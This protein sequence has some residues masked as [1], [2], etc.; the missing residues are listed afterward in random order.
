MN[1]DVKYTYHDLLSI[2]SDRHRYE[3]FQGDL[4]MT[5]APGRI[6]QDAV[7]NLANMLFTYLRTHQ[8][9]RVYVAPFDVYFDD[10]TVVQPDVLVVLRER[11]NIVDERRINGAPDLIVEI[12]SESTEQHDRGF[13][14]KR[15][16][17][18]GVKEYWIVDP[19]AKRIEINR[20]G[21]KGFVA[22]GVFSRRDEVVSPLLSGLRFT[23]DEVWR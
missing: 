9:G 12:T 17:Q 5:P 4:V 10:E 22:S 18:E 14:F 15:Y 3:I 1:V 11:L 21:E 7:M 2:P 8:L 16:A 23:A 19:M 6:H 20:L 13:K